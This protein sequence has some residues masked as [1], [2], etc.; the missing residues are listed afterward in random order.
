[1]RSTQ[2]S[3]WAD[4]ANS[5][6]QGVQVADHAK[7]AV[8]EAQAPRRPA[9]PLVHLHL[10]KRHPHVDVLADND[11]VLSRYFQPDHPDAR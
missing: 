7:C 6:I 11:E 3:R 8:L 10:G 5:V 9:Q 2:P 1:M 4:E